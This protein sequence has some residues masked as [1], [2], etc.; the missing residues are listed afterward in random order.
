[1][2]MLRNL[3]ISI[4]TLAVSQA[5]FGQSGSRVGTAGAAQLLIPVGSVGTS[6]GGS[7][8]ANAHGIEAIDWNPAGLSV[9]AKTAQAM[10]SRMTY[11]ADMDVNY[12]AAAG[13]F[14]DF[15]LLGLSVKWVDVGAIETT[16][17]DSPEGTG[18]DLSPTIMTIALTYSRAMTDRIH[19]GMNIKP[20]IEK[21]GTVSGSTM[22][23]DFG[24]QYREGTSGI[25]FGIALKNLGPR[26]RYD[27]TALEHNLVTPGQPPDATA[28]PLRVRLAP[29]DLPALLEMGLAYDFKVNENMGLNL[30]GTYLNHNYATDEYRVGGEWVFND[31]LY[32]RGGVSLSAPLQRPGAGNTEINEDTAITDTK[33]S[34]GFGVKRDIGNTNF[35]L[36]YA[37]RPVEYFGNTQWF[38]LSLGF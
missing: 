5:V 1:M 32:L 20:V 14:G 3:L 26:M 22:A 18:V 30:T 8:L 12:F 29:V 36:D 38:T 10:F 2:K 34:F 31:L 27:G 4:L 23:F 28:Q 17:I 11:I 37:Y 33:P 24:L 9:D 6:M 25:R 35:A 16:T 21:F 13:K 19:F 15:G 7:F